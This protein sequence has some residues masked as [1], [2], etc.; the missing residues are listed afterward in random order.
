M[1]HAEDADGLFAVD[2]EDHGNGTMDAD[3]DGPITVAGGL[4]NQS[5]AEAAVL[6]A[7]PNCVGAFP[8][9]SPL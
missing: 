9:A 8:V 6:R 2:G 7:E 1:A 3:T 4:E 5:S